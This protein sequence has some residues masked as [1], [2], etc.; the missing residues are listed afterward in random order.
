[1]AFVILGYK[2][3]AA[4]VYALIGARGE[5]ERSI[6][7]GALIDTWAKAGLTLRVALVADSA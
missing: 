7:T 2:A 3:L 4:W 6:A 5:L 1:M